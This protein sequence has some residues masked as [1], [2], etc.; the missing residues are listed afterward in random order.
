[1]LRRAARAIL[2]AV[3]PPQCAGCQRAGEQFCSGCRAQLSLLLAP[4]CPKCGYPQAGEWLCRQCQ[5]RPRPE[6]GGI[7]SAA[8]FEGPLLTAI[9]RF[10]YSN[11]LG[12][13]DAFGPLLKLC[14]NTHGLA[15]DAIVPVPLSWERQRQRGYNQ[16]G[17]LAGSLATE[18]ALPVDHSALRRI[19]NTASQVTLSRT[20]R[21]ANVAGAFRAAADRVKGR[22]FALVDDVC[23][24]GATLAACAEALREAGAAE[25]WAVTLARARWDALD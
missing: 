15:A 13:A 2:D 9:H 25:V 24:T 19:R 22:T 17:L 18:L 8:F 11:D 12:L 4:V 14:W 10:K 6:L 7:R 5:A 23:T 1:M 21:E 3:F 20:Q 16:A